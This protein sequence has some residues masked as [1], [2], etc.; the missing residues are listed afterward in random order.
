MNI[1]KVIINMCINS[2]KPSIVSEG[3]YTVSQ[4]ARLLGVHRSTIWRWVNDKK[5]KPIGGD[6]N[7]RKRF[8]G[9][10]LIRL[11]LNDI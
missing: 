5:L 9:S 7:V 11:W 10:D 6:T 8:L 3:R 2:I 4:A 1:S